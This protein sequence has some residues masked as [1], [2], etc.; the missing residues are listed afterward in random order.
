MVFASRGVRDMGGGVEPIEDA[1]EREQIACR[2]PRIRYVSLAIG[3]V[4]TALVWACP[5]G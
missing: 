2:A 3:A 4:L 1:A 5:A